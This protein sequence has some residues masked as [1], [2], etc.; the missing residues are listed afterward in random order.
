MAFDHFGGH[1]HGGAGHGFLFGGG[2]AG[3]AG[4]VEVGAV[5]VGGA[6]VGVGGGGR[7]GRVVGLEGFALAGD[8]FGGAEVDVFDYAVV[9]EEDVWRMG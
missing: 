7:C 8:D 6:G 5:G 1:V 4:G 3:G 9:V 2:D